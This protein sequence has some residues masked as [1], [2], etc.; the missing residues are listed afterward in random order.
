VQVDTYLESL[1]EYSELAYRVQYAQTRS[2]R[3]DAL[4]AMYRGIW[5][6]VKKL[7]C[8]QWAIDPHAIDWM[9]MLTPIEQSLWSEI[10][11]EGA[12]LYP[13]HPVGRYLVDFGH[14]V[15][16]VA[17]ECDGWRWHQD[18]ERDA[19]RQREIEAFGWKVYRLTGRDCMRLGR[20]GYDTDGGEV[21][22]EGPATVLLRRLCREYGLSK[23]YVKAKEE[24]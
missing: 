16:R 14:P 1:A 4:Q 11:Y 10:R 17:V 20:M 7:P 24:A 21:P 22:E 2:E 15:A 19:A 18:S 13:Q 12:V 3:C 5:P 9:P 8:H 6:T 23:R